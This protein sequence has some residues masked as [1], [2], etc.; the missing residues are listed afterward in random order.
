MSGELP[1]RINDADNHFV[2]PEDM[3]E[4]YIDPK[5]RDKAVRFV[6]DASGRRVQMYGDRPSKL[7]F[8]R[9]S[10]P[11]TR[12]ELERL[13]ASAAPQSGDES[14]AKPGDG[15]ARAPGMFL[16]RLNPYRNLD[17]EQRKALMAA[18]AAQQVAWGDRDLRLKLMDEQGI[19][20]AILYPGHVLNLE[21]EFAEDVDAICANARAYNRWIHA[22]VG[23][24]HAGRMFLPP[25]VSLADV[26]LAVEELERV[27]AEGAPLVEVIT[28]HAHGGRANPHGGRSLADPVFDPFWAR[29][30]E[31]RMRVCTHVGPT[32][33]QKYGADFS[34]D[35]DAVLRDFGAFQW[36]LYWGDRPAMDTVA[37]L[38]LHDLFG[39]FP[40]VRVCLSEQGTVW[41]PYLLR[42]LDA[43]YHLG[44][45][46]RFGKL[47]RRPSEIFRA[48]FVVAPFPEENVARVVDEVGIES[49][50]FGSDFPHAEGLA[51]PGDYVAAQLGGFPDDQVRAIMRDNLA[52]FL[53]IDAG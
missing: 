7:A 18:F 14:Q 27:I 4:R 10:A 30:N 51:F 8:T 17:E 52:R 13:A 21:Y 29:V 39:R 36:A 6:R 48:H 1:F 19:H 46:A 23:Y 24:A 31:A 11:Q 34:E 22:E 2:E 9:E 15:G 16:N 42:K 43:T 28:G 40:N 41:L 53:G 12:E 20:A 25:Y 47:D 32:D 45:P 44:R 37:S 3:Y 33:Y 26:D 35:P 49:I 50:V 5:Y 38:I